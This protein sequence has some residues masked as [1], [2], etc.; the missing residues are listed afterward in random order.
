MSARAEMSSCADANGRISIAA[1]STSESV[2]AR[3]SDCQSLTIIPILNDIDH[4]PRISL[5]FSCVFKAWEGG[6]VS[7]NKLKKSVEGSE[8][9]QNWVV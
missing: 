8:V 5:P 9:T 3:V 1:L 4:L 6:C 2:L 7:H